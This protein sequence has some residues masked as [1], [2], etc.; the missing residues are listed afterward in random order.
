MDF[1]ILG[2]F[3][4]V[5]GLREL[6]PS[7]P[8]LR[9]LLAMLVIR[10][11]HV[12]QVQEMI[13]ELWPESPPTSALPTL[14]T[15]IYKL[16]KLFPGDGAEA[17]G[18]LQTRH[19]GYQLVISDGDIDLARFE[20]LVADG[21]AALRPDPQRA[22]KILSQ[23]LS[24][25]RGPALSD[26]K[27]GELLTA[28]VTRIEECRMNALE[29]RIEA[30]LRLGRHGTLISE[31]KSITATHPL[32]EGLHA[33]LMLALYRCGRRGEALAAYQRLRR[34]LIDEL[35]LEPSAALRS[36]QRAILSSDPALDP[37]L[38]LTP[39]SGPERGETNGAATATAPV[40]V[41]VPV[42]VPVPAQLP[43]DIPDFLGHRDAFGLAERWLRAATD[44]GT[45][46]PV[47]VVTGM[48]GV[49]KTTF[50]LHAAHRVVDSFPGGQLFARL[51]TPAGEAVDPREVLAGF[52]KAAGAPTHD[53]PSGL[54]ERSALFRTWYARRSVLLVLDD[55]V[56]AGQVAPLLPGNPRCA[57]IVA[58]RSGLPGLSGARVVKLD[59]FS[60]E[61][62]LGLLTTV[63]GS[64]RV[65]PERDAAETIANL[66]GRLPLAL[67][68]A[69]SR[70]AA[71]P[72]WPLAKMASHLA[73]SANPL[74]E[75]GF[76]DVD[77]RSGYQATYQRL[78]D[79]ERSMFR[80]LALLPAAHFTRH[81][82]SDLLGLDIAV[83]EA[84]LMRLVE[85]HLLRVAWHE[86]GGD[87]RYAFYGLTRVFAQERLNVALAEPATPPVA[88]RTALLR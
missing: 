47:V 83:V 16:R 68:S 85:C 87:V 15:Y 72:G 45:A 50:A 65:D 81:E 56:H 28:Q 64:H 20:R 49:G 2:P 41:P 25:W 76:A 71:M 18:V 67:R 14:Q 57:V 66:C 60:V 61:E 12:V 59:P 78:T 63:L 24:L 79:L 22:T 32:H 82:V 29:L 62:A 51:R 3:Q 42:S 58:S 19:N 6:T 34:S 70:L 21:R 77:L 88:D 37:V 10:N 8:K 84:V 40:P 5:D 7:A 48:P 73:E 26:I 31:L 43:A 52:L 4:I 33:M 54:E 80:L 1:R 69:G 55:A 86:P 46:P 75:L 35:G 36:M 9:A 11:N 44:P 27:A 38:D 23:A 53:L 30:D 74:D 17:E 39:N 13:D